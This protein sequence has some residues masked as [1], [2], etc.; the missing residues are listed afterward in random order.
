M[1]GLCHQLRCRYSLT[2][3]KLSWY[4]INKFILVRPTASAPCGKPLCGA[5]SAP[6]CGMQRSDVV[7]MISNASFSSAGRPWRAL[8]SRRSWVVAGIA[9]AGVLTYATVIPYIMITSINASVGS[10]TLAA[11]LRTRAHRP[12]GGST[13]A[14]TSAA[15]ALPRRGL[16]VQPRGVAVAQ[17]SPQGQLARVKVAPTWDSFWGTALESGATPLVSAQ[18]DCTGQAFA[19]AARPRS[20]AAVCISTL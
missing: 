12:E 1:V 10:T 6:R 9:L 2:P 4:I 20:P 3:H 11:T 17:V 15:A 7:Q 16:A 18:L 8:T 14:S 13:G 19:I 5:H